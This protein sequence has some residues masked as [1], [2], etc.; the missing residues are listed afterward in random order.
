M[1]PLT[2]PKVRYPD[3][4]AGPWELT[5]HFAVLDGQVECVGVDVRSVTVVRRDDGSR[6]YRTLP[7]GD[8]PQRVTAA[9][10]RS[11]PIGSL[12]SRALER[13][14]GLTRAV[15][16]SPYVPK[17][18]RDEAA[19]RAADLGGDAPGRRRDWPPERLA[20]VAAV[21]REARNRR[22][23]PTKAVAERFSVSES[24][25]AKLVHRCRDPELGLL[26]PTTPGKAGG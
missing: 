12:M 26:G 25:A 3:D 6:T 23:P 22:Q 13:A 18:A 21:Y 10:V 24:M 14:R 5:F 17:D 4:D 2:S 15:A 1:P 19:T 11:L 9:L 7:Y 20:E 16:S 8:G